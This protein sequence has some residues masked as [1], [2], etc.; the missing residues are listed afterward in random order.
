MASSTQVVADRKG[1]D[2]WGNYPHERR[3]LFELIG[4]T[5]ASGV[6]LLS[7]N[8][9]FAELSRSEEG[10]YPL[11]DLTSSGLT[12]VD[13]EYA[14]APNPYRVAGPLAE[15]NFGLVEVD[16]RAGPAPDVRLSARRADGSKA[17]EHRV[18][19]SSLR[20]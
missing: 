8:V 20:A 1:M 17:F 7:G 11:Y 16:W 3:R 13:A 2:E 10:P 14:E 5:R 12:H 9:H 6:V 18:S 4:D 15:L 19:L